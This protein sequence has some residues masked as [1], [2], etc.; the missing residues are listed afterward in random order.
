[1]FN[2]Q[3]YDGKDSDPDL[4]IYSG[5]FF[6]EHDKKL[7][8]KIRYMSA[9][10]LAVSE[11]NF[12]DHRLSEMLFRYRARNYPQTLNDEERQ[13]WNMF[14]VNRVTDRQAGYGIVLDDYFRR[15]GDLRCDGNAN[16]EII[17]AL[18]TYALDKMAVLGI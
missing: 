17:D 16:T 10:Q 4:E 8:T 13:R 7:M 11:F 5:G 18:H 9:E 2:E 3:V 14:C 15:L 12:T 6:S 1:V